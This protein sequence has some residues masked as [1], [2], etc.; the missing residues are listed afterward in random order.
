[1]AR[2]ERPWW[3]AA[4]RGYYVI[5]NGKRRRLGAD[6]AAAFAEWH[7]IAAEAAGSPPAAPSPHT[8]RQPNLTIRELTDGYLA[9]QQNRVGWHRLH[10]LRSQLGILTRVW[11]GGRRVATLAPA[12]FDSLRRSRRWS[13]ATTTLA[14]RSWAAACNWAGIT[15]PL[16]GVRTG[17]GRT[18][19]LVLPTPEQTA[20]L[21][22]AASPALR[23]VIEAIHDTGCR[24][25]E[26]ATV[27]AADC[28][29]DRWLLR[30]TKGG[31]V[32]TVYLTPRLQQKCERLAKRRPTGPLFLSPRE[33]P[34]PLK[35]FVFAQAFRRLRVKCGLPVGL[36]L[37]SYRHSWA[38]DA[39]ERGVPEAV[40]A[41]QLGNTPAIL[42]RHYVHLRG[43]PDAVRDALR[44]VRGDAG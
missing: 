4:R 37:Y 43:R 44:R 2:K 15:N 29:G 42:L 1:M 20:T 21:L 10:S 40:V 33:S 26:V 7:R 8:L 41:E 3:W 35:S 24:P 36:T 25:C 13:P 22:A 9:A 12:D 39:I 11:G 38:T 30:E 17:R 23:D 28:R 18:R 31:K 16:R 19:E 27:T 34:W 6:R 32:R 5:I 14:K